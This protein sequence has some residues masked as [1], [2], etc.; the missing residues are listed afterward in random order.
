MFNLIIL[1]SKEFSKKKFLNKTNVC[2]DKRNLKLIT[3]NWLE[4]FNNYLFNVSEEFTRDNWEL[5]Q[6]FTFPSVWDFYDK[7]SSRAWIYA[8]TR[9]LCSHIVNSGM[10]RSKQDSTYSNLNWFFLKFC[11]IDCTKI[12]KG[13]FSLDL[14]TRYQSLFFI[15]LN[16]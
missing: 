5:Y 4:I 13:R 6:E 9:V 1:L 3:R 2:L 12:T 15:V 7:I 8:L 14:R 16:K 10:H 11:R